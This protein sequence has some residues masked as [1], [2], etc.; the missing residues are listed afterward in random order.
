MNATVAIARRELAEKRFVLLAAIAFAALAFVVPLVPGVH[1]GQK[2][3]AIVIVSTVLAVGFTLGLST[4]LGAT[5]IG[6]DLSEGR[7]S[8]YFTR[9]VPATAIWFGKLIAALIL[10]T[11]CFGVVV[12][13]AA[14]LGL[15]AFPGWT[16]DPSVFPA[17]VLIASVALLLLAHGIGTFVR[18]R[19]TWIAADFVCAAIIGGATYGL[20][21]TLLDGFAVELTNRFL[22]L[23]SA[24]AVVAMVTAGAWQ[25][26]QG[27]TDRRR[28]HLQFSLALWSLLGVAILIGGAFVWWVV[29]VRPGDLIAEA[30]VQESVG[31]WS[32]F[33]GG[34][35]N[36]GDYRAAFL[37]NIDNGQFLRLPADQ[38]WVA[39]V[40]FSNDGRVAVL[41]NRARDFSREVLVAHLDSKRPRPIATGIISD[42]YAE[43]LSPDGSR[44]ALIDRGGIL[45]IYDLASRRSLGS[46]RAPAGPN[47]AMSLAF[48][49]SDTLRIYVRD[50]QNARF[51]IFEYSLATK[52]LRETGQFATARYAML[53]FTGDQTRALIRSQRGD[54]LEVRDA[55]SGAILT[56]VAPH[57]GARFGNAMFLGDGRIVAS[58]IGTNSAMVRL[59]D[60]NGVAVRD[61]S[62]GDL[63]NAYVRAATPDDRII[64][65][66]RRSQQGWSAVVVDLNRGAILRVDRGLQP[67]SFGS[68]RSGSLLC[69]TTS[70]ELVAW[71]PMSGAKRAISR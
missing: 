25:L 39:P 37:Y 61:V 67:L 20:S 46:T 52:T 38:M 3:E 47:W 15:R 10:I 8:F 48:V 17:I 71:D 63:G 68:V 56:T 27:R 22:E 30:W 36:R 54:L 6:R 11:I 4:I 50:Q 70:K 64:V 21:R 42:P 16:G 32:Y 69:L 9:P 51:G 29:S 19:T 55:R 28:S 7:L 49:S 12:A 58:E 53:R 23:L 59:F 41:M 33:A 5:I 1:A 66:A 45:T 13:P 43:Q 26:A 18:S 57:S 24:F 40:L 14:L 35:R 60:P 31:P 2:R 62:L 44:L 65:T 34:A